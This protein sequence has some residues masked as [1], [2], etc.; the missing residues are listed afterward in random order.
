MVSVFLPPAWR[1][2]SGGESEIRF[3]ATTVRQV[4]A[5]LEARFP[6][7]LERAVADDSLKPGLSVAINGTVS[8]LGLRQP[9]PAGAEVHFLP[10]LGG[11]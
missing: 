4:L 1:D 10:A 3:E 2:L 5:G 9:V 8:R 6:G 7:I 11:G